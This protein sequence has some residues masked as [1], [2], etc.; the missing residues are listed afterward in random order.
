MLEL[1]KLYE[2][3]V[4]EKLLH[5]IDDP[6]YMY[7]H[8]NDSVDLYDIKDSNWHELQYVSI[9]NEGD[10]LGYLYARI[11]RQS[12]NITDLSIMKFD[13]DSNIFAI[14]LMRFFDKLLLKRNFNK[15]NFEV[16]IGNPIEA[17]YDKFVD[18]YGG[19]IVGVKLK[20][21][22]L[23]DGNHYDIKIY[24]ISR[25]EYSKNRT[26]FKRSSS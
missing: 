2:G 26:T 11:T 3:Q 21:T 20:D 12:R 5:T 18:K 13:K 10:V 22:V 25:E 16:V 14:D 24:E 19:R 9:N 7:Y 8:L 6:Y 4:K 23:M 1:A 17:M 15:I